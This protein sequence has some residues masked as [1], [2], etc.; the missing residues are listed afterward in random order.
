MTAAAVFFS[1]AARL[2]QPEKTGGFGGLVCLFSK[3]LPEQKLYPDLARTLKELSFA[4]VDLTVRPGG[5]VLPER[6]AEDLPRAFAA[7][8]E[9]GIGVP[10]ITTGLTSARDPAARPTLS[11]AARLGIPRYKLGYYPYGKL[12]TLDA[13]LAQVRA[14]L[15]GLVELGREAGIEAGFHNH[16]GAY[17][18]AAMW[19]AWEIV[20]GFD[21]HWIGF[22][23]DPCHATIEGGDNGWN[24]G[25]HR[26]ADRIKMVAVKDFFWEKTKGK[27][28]ARMCPLGG[29]MVDWKAFWALGGHPVPWP[30]LSAH[31]IRN[32]G[33]HRRGPAGKQSPGHRKGFCNPKK[34]ASRILCLTHLGPPGCLTSGP[35]ARLMEGLLCARRNAMAN[36]KWLAPGFIGMAVFLAG[37]PLMALQSREPASELDCNDGWH[38]DRLETFCEMREHTLPATAGSIRVDGRENGGV[39][40]KGW[41]RDSI[42][43]RAQVETAAE[44]EKEAEGLAREIRIET[45]GAQI[46]A[47]GPSSRSRRRW[48]VSYEV[49]VPRQSSLSLR[50]HNGGISIS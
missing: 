12:A 11:T 36:R 19:D 17:I 35:L 44:T 42:L 16:S 43:V 28:A 3:H 39:S 34:D 50:T 38:N 24:I 48:S 23:F 5:H 15:A 32:P 41:S 9:Q 2:A 37:G 45:A 30:H 7:L 18:G 47:E 6:V 14:Q 27:W 21:P 8:E 22:Y 29:G 49:F 46:Q 31:R 4:A 26:L 1:R 33:R 13:Q 40:V 25:F 10:M 20:H